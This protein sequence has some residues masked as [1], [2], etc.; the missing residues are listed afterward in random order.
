MIPNANPKLQ[1]QLE[2]LARESQERLA[3]KSASDKKAQYID[4]MTAPIELDGLKL[5]PEERA[6]ELK[7]VIFEHKGHKAA[8][9]ALRP[10]EPAVGSLI[11]EFQ[12]R[13][14]ELSVF[15]I[16]QESL[17]YALGFYKFVPQDSSQ[18]TSKVNIEPE[19][20]AKLQKELVTV[21]KVRDRLAQLF[22]ATDNI[23]TKEI[24]EVALAGAL[25][26]RASDLHFETS[27]GGFKLRY[28]IDGMLQVVIEQIP[29]QVYKLI[30][31][32]LKLLSNLRINITTESQDGRFT[33]GMGEVNIELRVS[34]VP[35]PFGESIVMRVLDPRSIQLELTDLG[36]RDDDLAIMQAEIRAPNGMILNTGPTGSGKTTTLY[37]FLRTI[38]DAATKTITIEDPV[39]YHLEGIEQTQVNVEAGY[40]FANGLSAMM[41]QD[42]DVI[43]VGEVRDTETAGIA[44]QAALTGHLV[45]STLHT[46]SASGAIPRLLDLGASP[47]SIGPA[48]NL[49]IAQ[50]LVR[51]LCKDCKVSLE[52]TPELKTKIDAF[53]K[54]LPER[55]KRPESAAITLFGP[56]EGGCETCNTHSY[57]GRVGIYELLKAGKEMETLINKRAGEGEIEDFARGRGMVM[58]QQDGILRVLKGDTS[59]EEVESVTG[60]LQ[61]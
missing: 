39:E 37:A 13:G 10:D 56:K 24:M 48:L 46:N 21:G 50:R 54:E 11:K 43:L 26:N 47:S 15:L 17:D 23:S 61:W 27:E 14:F 34:V 18:I 52:I 60:E 51:R 53:L 6:R 3:K 1:A 32:R 4:L 31:S 36:I 16:S 58:L 2:R 35:A 41:R 20:V 45:F 55:V 57:K 59:F 19:M 12:D 25:T 5:V 28:R 7:A 40:T 8:L 29:P 49:I 30:I 22:S 38:T 33:I 42:P 44:L 9:G